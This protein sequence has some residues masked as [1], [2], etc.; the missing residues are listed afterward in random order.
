MASDLESTQPGSKQPYPIAR[1]QSRP[2]GPYAW[3]KVA[4]VAAASALA[5]GLAAAWFYRNTLAKLRQA[6]NVEPHFESK[7]PGYGSEQD[8]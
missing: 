7:T 6:E 3:V 2:A 4:S 5:G 1:R 8:S